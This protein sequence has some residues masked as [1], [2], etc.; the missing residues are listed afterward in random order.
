M[1]VKHLFLALASFFLCSCGDKNTP[2]PNTTLEVTAIAPLTGTYGTEVTITG[3]NFNTTASNNIVK[4]NGVTAIVNTATA[5]ELKIIIPK[6]AGNGPVTVQSGSQS[7]TGP[8]WTHIYQPSI[9]TFAG[10]GVPGYADGAG[11]AAQFNNIRGIVSDASGN[12]FVCDQGNQ[13]IRKITPDGT[14]TTIAGDGVSGF[15]DGIGTAA[16]F[17]GPRKIAIDNMGNFFIT[18][19]S[20]HRIRKMTSAGVVTTLAGSGVNGFAD[21]PAAT[22]QFSFPVSIIADNS[23]NV[24]VTDQNYRVRKIS[25]TGSVST[26]A[27]N[28]T[29][30]FADGPA[31]TA[32]FTLIGGMTFDVSGNLIVADGNNHKIRKITMAGDVTTVAGTTSGFLNGPAATAKFDFPNDVL[33]INGNSFLISEPFNNRIRLLSA[34]LNVST[35]AGTGSSGNTDGSA[36]TATFNY[37]IS[38]TIAPSGIIYV[39]ELNNQ[40]I[41]K[42]IM[43]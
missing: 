10:S 28:G 42:I 30:G 21:G 14:V 20:N 24:Y 22:A 17:N 32:Q 1:K 11:T 4:V 39:G 16:R 6:N 3:K 34:G 25:N 15:A 26:L 33:S 27:G 19:V 13:R 12:I 18:D 38:I 35:Y 40:V 23:G 2:P 31:A 37:P 43:E 36:A 5:T 7:A 9:S 8:S 29:S 41:R